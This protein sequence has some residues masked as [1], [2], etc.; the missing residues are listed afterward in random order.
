M[1][2]RVD[3]M[4]RD[5]LWSRGDRQGMPMV[6]WRTIT[7]PHINGGLGVRRTRLANTALLGKLVWD[8]MHGGT[9]LWV[10]LVIGRYFHGDDLATAC[11]GRG[12]MECYF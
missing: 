2:D 6:A 10:Q 9:K 11:S 1:C 3:S 5:F 4:T 12:C 8:I 7:Q